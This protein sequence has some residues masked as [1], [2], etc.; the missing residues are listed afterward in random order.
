MKEGSKKSNLIILFFFIFLAVFLLQGDYI[1]K[2][3]EGL[4]LNGAWKIYNNQKIYADFF[5]YIPPGTFYIVFFIIKFFGPSYLAIKS[6]FI[7]FWLFSAFLI[8]KIYLLI[9]PRKDY[10]VIS[11]FSWL[12]IST[13]ASPLINHN[14][15]SSLFSIITI[16]LTLRLLDQKSWYNALSVGLF[17]SLTFYFLQTKGLVIILASLGVTVFY[18]QAKERVKSLAYYAIGL[19]VVFLISIFLW[20]REVFINPYLIKDFYYSVNE[21]DFYTIFCFLLYLVFSLAVSWATFVKNRKI[22][23]LLIFHFL[24]LFSIIN[25]FAVLHILIISF[26]FLIIFYNFIEIYFLEYWQN[27][28]IILVLCFSLFT[29]ITGLII[30]FGNKL[31]LSIKSAI[32]MEDLRRNIRGESFFAYPYLPNLYFELKS[33]DNYFVE[34]IE[35]TNK[36]LEKKFLILQSKRPEFVVTNYAAIKSLKVEHNSIDDYIK[37]NYYLIKDYGPIELWQRHK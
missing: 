19:F 37:N 15:L 27:K 13:V 17:A 30:S 5:E 33:Q 31:E 25:S 11:A 35:G 3:D 8:Y 2:S 32:I 18:L 1:L 12:A 21:L 34:T 36:F 24:L 7:L 9:S 23:P 4:I 20:G 28:F 29:V 6:F 14:F 22:G 10:A 16:Y 26:A